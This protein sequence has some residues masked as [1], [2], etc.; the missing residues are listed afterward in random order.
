MNYRTFWPHYVQGH[1]RPATRL[2]HFAGTSGAIACIALAAAWPSAWFLIAA[3]LS[4]Y[5]FA[6]ASHAFI[7]KNRPGTFRHPVL[8]VI[9]DFHMY[10]LMWAGRMAGEVRRLEREEKPAEGE[11]AS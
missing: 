1:R 2:F 6:W 8:S 9:G 11:P 7:E 4:G 10:A 5:G 3:P